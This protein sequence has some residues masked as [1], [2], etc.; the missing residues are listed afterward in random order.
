MMTAGLAFFSMVETQTRLSS[1]HVHQSAT[2]TNA[3]APR[4]DSVC[5]ARLAVCTLQAWD[6]HSM[7]VHSLIAAQASWAMYWHT[8]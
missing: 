2:V 6:E 4:I 5:T 1:F 7:S 3:G 8:A